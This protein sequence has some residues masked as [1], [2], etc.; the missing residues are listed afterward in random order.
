LTSTDGKF[1]P[2]TYANSPSINLIKVE[3]DEMFQGT[4][5]SPEMTPGLIMTRSNYS[6][7]GNAFWKSHAALSAISFDLGYGSSFFTSDQ[8]VGPKLSLSKSSECCIVAS[9]LV[10]TSF[11]TLFA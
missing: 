5:V 10:M 4:R 11:L 1:Q 9:E 7:S 6:S 3:V 2:E 8:S